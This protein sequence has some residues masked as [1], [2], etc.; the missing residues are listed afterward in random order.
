MQKT[1]NSLS[2]IVIIGPSG[3]GKTTLA[4]QLAR[5]LQIKHYEIDGIF[6]LPNWSEKPTEQ[7]HY[8]IEK[9]VKKPTWILCSGYI[10]RLEGLTIESAD[11][12]IWLNFR[13]HIFFW[14]MVKR[15]HKRLFKKEKIWDSNT[16]SFWIFWFNPR[17]SLLWLNVKNYVKKGSR[18]YLN[19]V[20]KYNQQHKVVEIRSPKEL[21]LWL[22]KL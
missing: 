4:R 18:H 19:N 16:E 21:D 1:K 10:N 11:V 3:S 9:I 6:W 5:K 17:K 8:E 22:Q 14:R 15:T 20:E 7:F 13:P 2:R 12:I